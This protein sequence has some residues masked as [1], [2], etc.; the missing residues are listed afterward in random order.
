MLLKSFVKRADKVLVTWSDN[1][2]DISGEDLNDLSEKFG[3]S[4]D[5]TIDKLYPAGAIY[6]QMDDE[7]LNRILKFPGSMIG[8]DGIPG[9]RHPHPRLW[10]TFPRVLGKY[11]REMKLFPLE[12]AVYKMTGKSAE[13][14]GLESRGTID[15]G[16]YA[17]LVIFNPET[18]IDKASYKSPKLHSEG[19][20]SVFVNGKVVWENDGATNN[21]PGMFLPGKKFD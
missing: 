6:F 4:I 15:V 1:Y 19:I 7:D 20:E 2:P 12:E 18:I 21:R 3:L 13:V 10:G 16:N 14:F 5:E 9:D 17:D 11:S 8:S